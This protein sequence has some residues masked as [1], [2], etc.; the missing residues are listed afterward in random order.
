MNALAAALAAAAGPRRAA[1]TRDVAPMLE[2]LN[3][4]NGY[5]NEHVVA[6][7]AT[8]VVIARRLRLG[9]SERAALAAAALLHD[10]GKITVPDAILAKP[11]PLDPEEWIVMRSHPAAGA[12]LLAPFVRDER[13]VAIVRGHHERWDGNGY[14]DG[15][16]GTAIPLGARI[17]A[18]ADAFQAMMEARPY[19][20]ALT[21]PVA[22]DTIRSEAGR[23]FDPVC[24][25]ALDAATAP[26]H[27][28]A[29]PLVTPAL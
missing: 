22:L 20:T 28:S 1:A 14:P 26:P 5:S 15:L 7:R 21:R 17:V 27:L 19:R 24:V 4:K 11:G 6:V 9:R 12:R 16:A 8:A 29:R 25:E 3:A 18:V 2:A 13:I 23:Q 10:V